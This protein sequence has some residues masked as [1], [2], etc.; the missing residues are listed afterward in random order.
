MENTQE[1]KARFFAQYWGQRIMA[2][3]VNENDFCQKIGFTHMNKYHLENCHIELKPLSSITKEHLTEIAK[4]YESTAHNI[5][6]NDD[7]VEFDFI[8]GDEHAS[9]A[10]QVDSDYCLDYL[11]SKG[12]AMDWMGLSVK[13]QIDHGWVKLKTI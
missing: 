10:I 13:K 6:L 5:K 7:Q 2:I 3:T 1:N 8:Y 4:F 9:G 11:R 12:F